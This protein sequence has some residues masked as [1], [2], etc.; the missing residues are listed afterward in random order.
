MKRLLTQLILIGILTNTSLA[1][2]DYEITN[3]Y[4]GTFTLTGSQTLLMTGGG[5][6]RIEGYNTSYIEIRN[7]APLQEFTGGI[8]SLILNNN[9]TMNYYGGDTA[10]FDIRG[11][12]H[13]VFKGGRIDGIRSY[14][15][16]NWLNW[17]PVDQHIEIIC[18]EVTTLTDTLLEGIWNVDSDNN[19]QWDTFSIQLVNQSGYDLV[20]DN[21]KITL[22]PEPASL[23][24]LALGGLLIR[25]K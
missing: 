7:T 8:S 23:A 20:R 6:V 14:Q 13:A 11:Q 3:G 22:V 4:H 19:G 2:W 21:I 1:A 9:T 24:L 15:Y 5:T 18:R 17:E 25:R 12:A 16:V 10:L